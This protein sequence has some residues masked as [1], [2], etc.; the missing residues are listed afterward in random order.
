VDLIREIDDPQQASRALLDHALGA[1]STD[2]L[3]VLV[4]ALGPKAGPA[5]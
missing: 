4:I 3:S 1:F 5:A 2:N